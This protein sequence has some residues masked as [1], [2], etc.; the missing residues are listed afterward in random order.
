M[1]GQ[2]CRYTK[3]LRDSPGRFERA[4]SVAEGPVE[5]IHVLEGKDRSR[6]RL[7]RPR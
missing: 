4:P 2:S 3:V 5:R 1:K 7:V 6:V